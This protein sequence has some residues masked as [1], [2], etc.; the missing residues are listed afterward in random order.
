MAH[1]PTL[2]HKAPTHLHCPHPSLIVH[3]I[4]SGPQRLYKAISSIIVVMM[5]KKVLIS[6]IFTILRCLAASPSIGR[7]ARCE[8]ALLNHGYIE[9]GAKNLYKCSIH[10]LRNSGRMILGKNLIPSRMI[11]SVEMKRPPAEPGFK[12]LRE[13]LADTGESEVVGQRGSKTAQEN[14][15]VVHPEKVKIEPAN[16]SR[17]QASTDQPYADDMQQNADVLALFSMN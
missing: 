9:A 13:T 17:S 7:A 2:Y 5:S 4:A 16:G 11:P 1:I 14:R 3:P 15:A 6:L 10:H 12:A 8:G